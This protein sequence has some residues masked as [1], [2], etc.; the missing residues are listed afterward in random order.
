MKKLYISN[1]VN[2]RYSVSETRIEHLEGK[3]FDSYDTLMNYFKDEN[4]EV[5]RMK[6]RELTVITT[7][8]STEKMRR[9]EKDLIEA[10]FKNFRGVNKE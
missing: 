8:M 9:L 3:T 5:R 2:D 4:K 1:G 7:G 6:S 10:G